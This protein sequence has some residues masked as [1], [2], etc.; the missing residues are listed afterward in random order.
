[1]TSVHL[2]APTL[3]PVTGLYAGLLALLYVVLSFRVIRLRRK[4]SRPF[5]E[6]DC[7]ELTRAVRV[8]GHFAEYVPLA[9]MLLLMLELADWPGWALHLYGALLL[10]SRLI[11]LAGLSRVPERVNLR[12]AA[13]VIT[14]N[15]LAAAAVALLVAW[16]RF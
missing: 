4:L 14:L 16:W 6:G 12:L 7:E 15:L 13:M 8:H 1:M 11:H 5:G 9:L 2:S 3:A 10:C